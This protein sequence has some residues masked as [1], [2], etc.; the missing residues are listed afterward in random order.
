[1]LTPTQTK[2]DELVLLDAVKEYLISLGPAKD[3]DSSMKRLDF[4]FQLSEFVCFACG[5]MVSDCPCLD[6]ELDF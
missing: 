5:N 4:I 1:M 6:A 2:Q 3:Y